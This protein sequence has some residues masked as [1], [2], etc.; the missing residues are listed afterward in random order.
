MFCG[1]AS[2]T[3]WGAGACAVFGIDGSVAG[4]MRFEVLV[5]FGALVQV[6]GDGEGAFLRLLWGAVWDAV[7]GHGNA[8]AHFVEID[9]RVL[10]GTAVGG[11]VDGAT[12]FSQTLES[13][14]GFL[15]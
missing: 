2:G 12:H 15:F 14:K 13:F 9:G 3:V 1:I 7:C 4:G 10:G 8:A 11:A 6:A 5:Q